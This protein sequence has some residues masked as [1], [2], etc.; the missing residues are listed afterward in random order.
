MTPLAGRVAVVTGASR[1]I[2]AA[3]AEALAQAGAT[4]ARLAR[5]L[6]DASRGP[7]F[8]RTCDLTDATLRRR[9]L[10]AVVEEL[11][12]PHIVVNNAGGFLLKP[13]EETGVAEFEA[14]LAVNLVGPFAVARAL[15]PWMNSAGRGHLVTIGS[16]ADHVPLP[17]NSAYAASKYGLRGMHESLAAEYRGSGVRFT[18][19]SPGP[20]DTALWDPVGPDAR[21]GFTP[22]ARMLRPGDVADAVLFAVTRPAH[23]TID[24]I[25]LSPG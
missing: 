12:P 22:R 13:L 17:E 2:G 6:P 1:G 15:L 23:A 9:A 7:F 19:V 8:D 18:L 20:T 24:L 16:I 5:S 3:I 11:G 21:P 10:D 4:V 25:R 14:Q